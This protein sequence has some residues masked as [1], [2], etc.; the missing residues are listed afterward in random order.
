[1]GL[2]WEAESRK[3]AGKPFFGFHARSPDAVSHPQTMRRA[4][5]T[6]APIPSP[7][8]TVDARHLAAAVSEI[9]D[10]M[11]CGAC[12]PTISQTVQVLDLGEGK[13]AAVIIT[14]TTEE[15][16]FL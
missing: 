1:M 10:D 15:D 9:V 14:I 8:H 3:L 11:R 16:R 2:A 5:L 12:A 13:K 6:K 7:G 4:E